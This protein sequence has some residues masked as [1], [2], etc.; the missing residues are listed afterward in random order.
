MGGKEG[1]GVGEGVTES[2]IKMAKLVVL[3]PAPQRSFL[4]KKLSCF[5]EM[6]V[7]IE[8]QLFGNWACYQPS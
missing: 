1:E 6:G 8:Y 4:V 3:T 5:W 2:R 7:N